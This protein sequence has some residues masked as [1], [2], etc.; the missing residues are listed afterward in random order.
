MSKRYQQLGNAPSVSGRTVDEAYATAQAA[1][2]TTA[3]AQTNATAALVAA[4]AADGN[5]ATALANASSAD[6]KASIAIRTGGAVDPCQAPYS[7]VGDGVADDRAA[8][9]AAAAVGPVAL[10]VGKVFRI[11]SNLTLTYGL[12]GLGGQIKPDSA[13]TLT[14]TGPPDG[15]NW[16]DASL[17]GLLALSGGALRRLPGDVISA[18][19]TDDTGPLQA[20]IASTPSGGGFDLERRT[21]NISAPI[22]VGTNPI[23]ISATHP[24][25]T[26][27]AQSDDSAT[28]LVVAAG[29]DRVIH[30]E[31]FGVAGGKIGF[32]LPATSQLHQLSTIKHLTFADQANNGGSSGHCMLIEGGMIGVQFDQIGMGAGG[33]VLCDYGFKA[34]GDSLLNGATLRHCTTTGFLAHG[35]WIEQTVAGIAQP[36]ITLENCICQWNWGTGIHLR[37][38]ACNL[39]SQYF[40]GNGHYELPAIVSGTDGATTNGASSYLV[41][42]AEDFTNARQGDVLVITGGADAGRYSIN[43]VNVAGDAVGIVGTFP[44]GGLTGQTFSV[45]RPQPDMEL[46]E[47]AAPGV[48][49]ACRVIMLGPNFGVTGAGQ[50]IDVTPGNNRRISILASGVDLTIIKPTFYTTDVIDGGAYGFNLETEF[51]GAVVLQNVIGSTITRRDAGRLQAAIIS[52]AAGYG[53]ERARLKPG[54]NY[55]RGVTHYYDATDGAWRYQYIDDGNIVVTDSEPT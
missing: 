4:T 20:K 34:S 24:T 13:I 52:A 29:T 7:A 14:L 19:G 11:A 53:V 40:E 5:A 28:S 22:T 27:I 38:V 17:G 36:A 32:H 12:R 50:D 31:R 41:G 16:F 49:S 23:T 15:T 51:S 30:L 46:D 33:G 54:T 6:A 55:D 18:F 10:K 2:A 8:L 44:S 1:K 42:A 26:V 47:T 37:G 48:T 3:E 35:I 39:I 43:V 21:H 45:V 9:A 25:G